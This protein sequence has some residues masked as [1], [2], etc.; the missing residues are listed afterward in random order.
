MT[1]VRSVSSQVRRSLRLRSVVGW[2]WWTCP[3]CKRRFVMSRKSLSW[4]AA[5]LVAALG[6]LAAGC[7]EHPMHAEQDVRASKSVQSLTKEEINRL[8][9]L[10]RESPSTVP[11]GQVY[12]VTGKVVD[13]SI[14]EKGES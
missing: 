4:I 11:Y 1:R 5:G 13:V 6:F 14:K 8:F 3:S 10:K 7:E 9:L 12:E 2:L